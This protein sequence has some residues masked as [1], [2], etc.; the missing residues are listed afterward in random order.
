M[1]CLRRLLVL[2]FVAMMAVSPVATQAAAC[3]HLEA[4]SDVEA[5]EG[6]MGCEAISTK[7]EHHIPAKDN[8]PSHSK[9]CCLAHSVVAP[10][11]NVV[12]ATT[13]SPSNAKIGLPLDW[14][15]VLELAPNA[16]LRPPRS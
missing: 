5:D 4:A 12:M 15:G 2:F 3:L 6:H 9:T 11:D 16:L 8:N 14:A 1:E 13:V 10:L 7:A